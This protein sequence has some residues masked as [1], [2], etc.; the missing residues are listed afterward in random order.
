MADEES[1]EHEIH[2]VL[3]EP[4]TMES[5]DAM[6]GALL[7]G[8]ALGA[9]TK[10][11]AI[12]SLLTLVT[13]DLKFQD[14]M[15]EIL[16]IFMKVVKSEAGSILELNYKDNTFFFRAAAGVSSDRVV[17]FVIPA[18]QGI[19]GYVAE[20][21]QALLISALDDEEKHLKD[22][23]KAVGFEARN[24]VALPIVIRGRVFAVVELLNRVGEECYTPADQELLKYIC[25]KAARAIEIRLM[26][27]WS[28]QKQTG[29]AA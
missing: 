28:R 7:S 23:T 10:L 19:V 24:M 2:L 26:I 29:S 6:G 11:S 5:P 15:R 9:S 14:F 21:R 1:K 8:D 13:R 25:E 12:E 18:G 20:S 3:E 4:D 22:I 17:K 16:M 27:A